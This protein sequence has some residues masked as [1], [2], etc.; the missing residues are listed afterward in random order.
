[1]LKHLWIGGIIL[2]CSLAESNKTESRITRP[3]FINWNDSRTIGTLS[4]IAVYWVIAIPGLIVIYWKCL[5]TRDA[6]AKSAESN[7]G[8]NHKAR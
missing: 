4:A 2:L 8:P 6:E 1:M 7:E 5:Y 3:R